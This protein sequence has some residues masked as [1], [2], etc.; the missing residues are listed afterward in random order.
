MHEKSSLALTREKIEK[1]PRLLFIKKKGLLKENLVQH[2]ARKVEDDGE[3]GPSDGISSAKHRQKPNA[4]GD[5]ASAFDADFISDEEGFADKSIRGETQRNPKTDR[6]SANR[7]RR[8]NRRGKLS[9]RQ[10]S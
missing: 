3:D 2:S 8:R 5:N 4:D 1:K 6:S 10:S 7:S 9:Q